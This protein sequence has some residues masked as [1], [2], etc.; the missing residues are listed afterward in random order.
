[1]DHHTLRFFL[2]FWGRMGLQLLWVIF[3]V[4]ETKGD[5][6]EELQERLNPAESR[7]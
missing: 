1:M 7:P 2:F 5:P 4:P 3:I 6:L